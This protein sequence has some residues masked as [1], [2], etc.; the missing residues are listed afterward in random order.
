MAARAA[1]GSD[2]AEL[3]AA[4]LSAVGN[5]DRGRKTSVAQRRSILRAVEAL[6]ACN[7]TASPVGSE[8]ISGNWSLLYTEPIRE[9]DA[10]QRREGALEGPVLS[11]LRPLTAGAVRS[12]GITQ[13]GL[14]KLTIPLG[15]A[16]PKGWVET[17]YLDEQ[18][19]VGRGDK[20]SLFVTVRQRGKQ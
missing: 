1:T 8:L 17:T 10:K 6:E 2:L 11:R 18:M 12:K 13:L 5:T 19:R 15:W 7:P 16:K 20:G 4:V 9:G 3:K 14:L